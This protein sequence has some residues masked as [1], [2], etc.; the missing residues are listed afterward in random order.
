MSS[1]CLT[2]PLVVHAKYHG[3]EV[4]CLHPVV[5]VNPALPDLIYRYRCIVLSGYTRYFND[6][7]ARY[8]YHY[9][10][11]V[12]CRGI[13][14]DNYK[15]SYVLD[16][17]TGETFPVYLLVPCNHCE[18]CQKSKLDAIAHRCV[19]E[20][21]T[22]TSLPW[23]VTLTYNNQSLPPDGVR[24]DHVQKFLKRLRINLDRHGYEEKI[25]YFVSSEYSP[26]GRPHYHIIFWN[27]HPKKSFRYYKLMYLIQKSW[28]YGFA[29]NEIV[30]PKYRKSGKSLGSPQ[31]CFEYVSKY[32]NKE[33]DVPDGKNPTFYTSSNRGGGIGAPFLDKFVIPDIRTSLDPNFLFL[34]VF[35]PLGRT[36]HLYFNRYVLNRCFPTFSSSVSLKLRNAWRDLMMCAARLNYQYRQDEFER[37]YHVLSDYL[38]SPVLSSG[39][40]LRSEPSCLISCPFMKWKFDLALSVILK[41]LPKTDFDLSLNL[42]R[43]RKLF[44]GKLLRYR[45]PRDL[46]DIAY[47]FRISRDKTRALVT[48]PM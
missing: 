22:Y 44:V 17:D 38:P 48:L 5:I 42:D 10:F 25:R 36:Q 35:A 21:M 31:K 26:V 37:V 46:A 32:I 41:Y 13:D 6:H 14:Y 18:C 9:G 33:S 40:V 15:E 19:L 16:Q 47:K 29:Y 3:D 11:Q 27:I 4:N 2:A 7:Q 45:K 43:L 1:E 23:F 8:I 34:N 12:S 30:S 20:T 28:S 39:D 24:V